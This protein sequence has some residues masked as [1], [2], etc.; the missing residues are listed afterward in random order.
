MTSYF[1][2]YPLPE[3]SKIIAKIIEK[4]NRNITLLT[5]INS[6]ACMVITNETTDINPVNLNLFL[7]SLSL[8]KTGI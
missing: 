4:K 5:E 3:T 6:I 1:L 2:Y 8:G 7:T